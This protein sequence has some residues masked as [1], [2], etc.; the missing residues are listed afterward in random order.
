M[1]LFA[2]NLN[3]LSNQQF[4]V[5]APR[6]LYCQ[7]KNHINAVN[8]I[9]TCSSYFGAKIKADLGLRISVCFIFHYTR[10][11]KTV[12]LLILVIYYSNSKIY[13]YGCLFLFNFIKQFSLV[14]YYQ[15]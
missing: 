4:A 11:S 3:I 7:K 1:C 13:A 2:L 6:L 12:Y 5:H 10:V 14:S 8:L 15:Q 9:K